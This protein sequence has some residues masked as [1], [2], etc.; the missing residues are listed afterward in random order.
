MEMSPLLSVG[1]LADVDILYVHTEAIFF[2]R[3]DLPGNAFE[4]DDNLAL[5]SAS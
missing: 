2:L 1:S 5:G 3:M 4:R